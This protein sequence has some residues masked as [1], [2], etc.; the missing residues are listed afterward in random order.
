MKFPIDVLFLDRAKKILK[1]RAG[2]GPRR[3]ALCLRAHSVLE[4]PSG[5][6]AASHTQPGDQLDF[7]ETGDSA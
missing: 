1:I 2:M 5:A 3:L 7:G 4:L 6:A